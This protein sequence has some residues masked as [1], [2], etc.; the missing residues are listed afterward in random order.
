[1]SFAMYRLLAQPVEAL[2]RRLTMNAQPLH[3]EFPLA[4]PRNSP[5]VILSVDDEPMGKTL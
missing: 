1:M 3:S 2:E 4:T 5:K